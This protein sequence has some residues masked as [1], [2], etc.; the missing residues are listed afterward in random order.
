MD[1]RSFK[2]GILTIALGIMSFGL[3]D[4]NLYAMTAEKYFKEK[5]GPGAKIFASGQLVLAGRRVTCGRRKTV[6]D[7]NFED[8]GGAYPSFIIL[9]PK[10]MR[11]LPRSIKLYIFAHECGHQFRGISE[12]DADCF[13]V[14]RGRRQGWL[15]KTGLQEICSFL[16][17]YAGSRMHPPGK[18]RCKIMRRCYKNAVR[19]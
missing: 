8:F 14:K 11:G 1:I 5:A 2:I 4:T 13:A 15:T 3:I 17:P 18:E 10:K 7:S 16:L 12:E 19:R 9:N 6:Y